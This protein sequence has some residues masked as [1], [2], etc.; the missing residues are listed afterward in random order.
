MFSLKVQINYC[1]CLVAFNV[2]L[3]EGKE[4]EIKSEKSIFCTLL[5]TYYSQDFVYPY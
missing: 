1:M 4:R 3:M 5:C 2:N